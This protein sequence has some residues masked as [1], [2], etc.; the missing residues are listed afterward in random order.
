[1]V[2]GIDSCFTHWI[3]TLSSST[4]IIDAAVSQSH[5]FNE[6]TVQLAVVDVHTGQRVVTEFLTVEGSSLIE[7]YRCLKSMYGED[8][9]DVR[10]FN[11][12]P[13]I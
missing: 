8:A 11:A 1:M 12:G 13:V 10:S 6:V 7:I 9:M 2:L 4:S 3:E 5:V